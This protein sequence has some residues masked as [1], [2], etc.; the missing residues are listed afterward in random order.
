MYGSELWFGPLKSKLPLRQFGIGY[1]KAIKK[2]LQLSMHESNHFA[3]QEAGLMTFSH[4][5]CKMKIC[6]V[7]R[8]ILK[9]CDF[10]RNLLSF[11]KISSIMVNEVQYTL[12]TI[13]D[14]DSVFDNDVEAIISRILFVQ[15]NEEQMRVTW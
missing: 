2:I 15:R 3:C 7:M 12:K 10:I 14:I 5:L 11:M 1:H 6:S 9:L 4:L 13:Y 8:F